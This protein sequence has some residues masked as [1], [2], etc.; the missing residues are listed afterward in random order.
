MGAGALSRLLDELK[1]TFGSDVPDEVLV[2]MED[3]DDALVWK[4]SADSALIATIDFFTPIVDDPYQYGAISA[5]NAMSDVFAMGGRIAFALN[6]AAFPGS[7]SAGTTAAILRG[8]AEKVKEAGGIVGGGHTIVDREPKYGL[9]V[10][11]IVHPDRILTKAGAG[12]GDLLYLTKPCGTG[13][14]TTA[15][16]GRKAD[17]E[18]LGSAVDSMLQLNRQAAEAAVRVGVSAATDIT[19]FALLGHAAEMA[20]KSGADLEIEYARVPFLEG[21]KEYGARGL[22]PGGTFNNLDYYASRLVVDGS[23]TDTDRNI[24]LTPETSGGLLFAVEQEKAGALEE[25]LTRAGVK[26]RRIGRVVE[27]RGMIRVA[28]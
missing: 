6:V 16:K 13:L 2:G 1:D 25:E 26:V 18:H 7:L 19:G 9:C 12:P 15:A 8:G 20:E 27:G 10:V 5:A 24:L 17:P 22:F 11:G 3:G 21:A 23:L 28:P 4:L 14:I